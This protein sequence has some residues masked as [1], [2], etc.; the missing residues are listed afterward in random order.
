MS[1]NIYDL[2]HQGAMD[3]TALKSLRATLGWSQTRL[4][5]ELGVARNTVTRW[6]MGLNPIPPMAQRLI[7]LLATQWPTAKPRK[8]KKLANH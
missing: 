4:A 3:S 2:S 8:P 6:E 7:N 1:R 5:E